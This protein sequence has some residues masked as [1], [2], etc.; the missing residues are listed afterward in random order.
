MTE[1]GIYRFTTAGHT[2]VKDAESPDLK[3]A[4]AAYW[5]FAASLGRDEPL[6]KIE[7]LDCHGNVLSETIGPLSP[8][9]PE[10]EY[11]NVRF[12][13]CCGQDERTILTQAEAVNERQAIEDVK[14]WLRGFR[15][16]KISNFD[17]QRRM[18]PYPEEEDLQFL[19]E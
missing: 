18:F 10:P 3:A 12:N 17:A 9:E 8:P 7:L 2:Y 13:V 1:I 4:E 11:Y 14:K 6:L 5:K 16:A 15:A 19:E